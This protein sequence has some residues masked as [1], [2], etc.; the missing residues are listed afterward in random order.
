MPTVI[1]HAL[2]PLI[3]AAAVPQ[4]RLTRPLIMVGMAAAMLPDADLV[5]RWFGVPHAADFGHRGATHTLLFALLIGGAAALCFRK[6][7]LS[8]FLFVMLS[9]LSHSLADM[10]TGGGKGI[11]LLWPMDHERW[12]FLVHPVQVSPIGLQ[13]FESGAIWPVFASEL[14]WLLLPAVLLAAF[15]RFTA[16]SVA[17]RPGVI[18]SG[19]KPT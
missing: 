12:K 8:A 6:R 7:R 14:M 11:M 19:G 5:S 3:G 16:K 2:L 10:L 1:T 18:D 9:N 17:A 4:A 13:G 15:L